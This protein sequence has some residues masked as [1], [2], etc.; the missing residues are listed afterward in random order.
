MTGIQK[1]M[2]NSRMKPHT[3]LSHITTTTGIKS[4]W[5]KGL[6]SFHQQND[7]TNGVESFFSNL[8]KYF[9]IS[10]PGPP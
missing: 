5:V 1:F 3:Q 6:K 9:C 2:N 8:K 10:M 7:T 4:E